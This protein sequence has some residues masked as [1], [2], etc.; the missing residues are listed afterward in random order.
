MGVRYEW[1]SDDHII[2]NIYIESP[3]SW[4]ENLEV[5]KK[6][7]ALLVDLNHPCATIVDVRNYG[8]LPRDGNIIQ[9]LLNVDRSMPDNLFASAIVG[10]PYGVTVFMNVL[11]KLSTHAERLALFTS[12]MEEARERI[13]ARYHE[14]QA[15][16]L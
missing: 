14:L 8:S 16:S 3:W 7:M 2:A 9:I 6:L 5:V 4:T 11:T 10:A 12:S 1:D 15:G 13:L